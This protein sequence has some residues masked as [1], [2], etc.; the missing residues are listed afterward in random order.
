MEMVNEVKITHGTARGGIF[1]VNEYKQVIVPVGETGVYYYAGPYDPPLHFVSDEG[2]RITGDPVDANGNPMMLGDRWNGPHAGIPYVLSAGGNDIYYKT[3]PRPNVTKDILLS[4]KRGKT[5]AGAQIARTLAVL[6]GP[7]GGRF[8]V[9]EFGAIFSPVTDEEGMNYVYF[10]KID[11]NSWFPD[12]TVAPT[13]AVTQA[14]VA[15]S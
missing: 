10:G 13:Q 7:S 6:K 1:Y 4:T 14:P 9:N 5:V 2:V 3:R 15:A 11:M 12:P 8:Y